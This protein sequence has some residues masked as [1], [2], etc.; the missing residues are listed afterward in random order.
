MQV[1]TART[2]SSVCHAHSRHQNPESVKLLSSLVAASS[3][4]LAAPASAADAIAPKQD[5]GFLS[6]I[7]DGLDFVLGSIESFFVGVGIPDSYGWSIVS[8]TLFVKIVTL[9]FTKKQVESA[10][11][12]QNLKPRIDVIKERYG[13]DKDKIQKETARLYEKAEVNPFA[14]CGPSILQLPIFF[15]LFRSLNNVALSGDLDSEGW[16]WIPS[17]SGPV[18]AAARLE[19]NGLSWLFP[20]VDGAPPI[21]WDDASPYLVLPVLLVLAQY[22]SSLVLSPIDPNDENANTQRTLIYGLPALVGYFSLTVPSGLSLYYFSNTVFTSAIQFYFRKLGGVVLDT[23]DLGPVTKLGMGRKQGEV[24]FVPKAAA[25]LPEMGA[26]GAGDAL[27]AEFG[28]SMAMSAPV[29]EPAAPVTNGNGS[30][31]A[32][33]NGAAAAPAEASSGAA[34]ATAEQESEET[35]K[36]FSEGDEEIIGGLTVAQSEMEGVAKEELEYLSR[37]SKRKTSTA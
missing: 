16:L 19:G 30:T 17:L 11:A 7:V 36:G 28:G 26:A 21:G 15:G 35:K 32:T 33:A 20:L 8:L 29:T 34:A 37:R 10:M 4:I 1:S 3:A 12:M 14:G 25:S 9:P 2:E 18:S 31:A 6:P 27:A 5:N 22:A 24:V 13:D 23:P